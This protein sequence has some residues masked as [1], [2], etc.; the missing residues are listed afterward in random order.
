VSRDDLKAALDALTERAGAWTYDIPLAPGVW[1]RGNEGTPHTR[2]RRLVQI[3]A[4]LSGKP[5]ADLR[6]LDLGCLEGIMALELA[7]HGASAVGVEIREAHVLKARFCKEALDLP[8]IEFRQDDVRNVSEETYG[9]FDV[10]LCSG[11][12]YHLPAADAARLLERLSAMVERLL[13]LDT[14]VA[15]K[16]RERF[17]F[18]GEEYWGRTYRE[19]A[20][21]ATTEQKTRA[22]WAS[23]DNATSFWFTRPSLV[24]LLDEAGFSSVYECFNPAHLNSG[25]PGLESEDRCTFVAIKGTRQ[26]IALSPA[27][28]KLRER[29]PEDTL[30]YAPGGRRRQ[31]RG[32]LR[33]LL[34]RLTGKR[35]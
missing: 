3:V 7:M 29:W 19:H 26:P 12:L 15:L 4:D 16:P 25:K 35:A 22:G 8:R 14:H 11:L 17:V 32:P 1:T 24:N 28:E 5:L 2:L 34:R 9:R 6:V 30:K 20:D 27:V 31:R 18:Q 13:V 23:A 10:V 21:D 33:D